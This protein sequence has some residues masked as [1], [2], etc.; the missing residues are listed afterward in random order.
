MDKLQPITAKYPPSRFWYFVNWNFMNYLF[1]TNSLKKMIK[2][3]NQDQY[4][5]VFRKRIQEKLKAIECR[6][7]IEGDTIHF[8]R[9]VRNT[10][11]SGMNKV[12]AMKI[13]RE[14]AIGIERM[15]SGK[16]KIYWKVKLDAIL[17]LSILTGI[18]IAV[19]A[20]FASSKLIISMAIGVLFSIITYFAGCSVI[21]SKIDELV[22]SSV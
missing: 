12:E 3:Q 21:K 13:L 6:S 5:A 4:I 9:I 22:E 1:Y 8:K 16:I 11:H 20:G 14:G 7:E 19:I 18:V 17:F 10:T 2:D 15:N